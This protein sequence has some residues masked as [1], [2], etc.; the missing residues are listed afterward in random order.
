MDDNNNK[1]ISHCSPCAAVVQEPPQKP[2]YTLRAV[3]GDAW[4]APSLLS[5]CHGPFVHTTPL[6]R[7]GIGKYW[8]NCIGI[9]TASAVFL[10]LLWSRSHASSSPGVRVCVCVRASGTKVT[11]QC[12]FFLPLPRHTALDKYGRQTVGFQRKTH[13]HSHTFCNSTPSK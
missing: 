13:T 1:H 11:N 6:A 12:G 4:N 9:T 7:L 3:K 2:R 10:H 5:P 8:R